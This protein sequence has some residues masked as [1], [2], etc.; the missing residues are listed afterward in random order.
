VRE[1][2]LDAFLTANQLMMKTVTAGGFFSLGGMTAVDVHGA[3]VRD[4]IF[5][6]TVVAFT[7]LLAD[8][9]VTT[10]DAQTP[11]VGGWS[12]LQFA[13]VSLGGLGIVTS[14]TLEVL[15]RPYATTLAASRQ[16]LA[17]NDR[18]AF[19]AQYK[20]WLTH[21]RVESFFNPYDNNYLA[22]CWDVVT[23][24]SPKTPNQ[25]PSPDPLSA[26]ALAGQTVFGAPD[27]GPF[28]E[29][30][31]ETTGVETQNFPLGLTI[32]R[33]AAKKLIGKA[34]SVIE[35]MVDTGAKSFSELWLTEAVRVMFMSYYIELPDLG[36]AGLGKVW[37]GLNVITSL[38]NASDVKF[39]LAGPLEFR[40]VR[41]GSSAMSSAYTEK[42]S[43]TFVN[44]DLIGFVYASQMATQYPA[45]LQQFFADVE[46]QWV[47]MGGFPHNGKMY[48]FY[49][50]GDLSRSYSPTGP[51]NPKFLAGLR[52]RRGARL[53]AYQNFRH[54]LDPQGLFYNDYVKSLLG[55]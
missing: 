27:E 17:L 25:L 53:V 14:M 30:I 45:N 23:N 40:F 42:S 3:T 18:A 49:D 11:A 38:I 16:T 6:E 10:I 55:A 54:S 19:I 34:F 15:P 22:L 39:L 31:A 43:S 9:T 48:G 36:D 37:D 12:P 51:F 33:Y 44:L 20:T 47:A 21:D 8:G 4:P 35:G 1:D 32:G 29:P 50:P 24:P 41:G 5:A 52:D 46:R 26:C 2:E 13:R 7:L 28:L